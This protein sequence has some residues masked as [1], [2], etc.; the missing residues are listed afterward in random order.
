MQTGGYD[1][2]LEVNETLMNRFLNLGH[3]IGKFPVFTGTYTLPIDDVPESLQEFM[4]IGYEVSVAEP[5][6]IDFTPSL[7]ARMR[8]RGQAK[9]TVLGGIDFEI[10]VEFTIGLSPSFNQRQ[11]NRSWASSTVNRPSSRSRR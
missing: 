4:D 6:T 10:E 1:I 8:A 9:F 11:A 3:C 2:V 5:P 7:Q